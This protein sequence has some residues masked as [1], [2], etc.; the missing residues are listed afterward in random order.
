MFPRWREV[1][2]LITA[3]FFPYIDN[4]YCWSVVLKYQIVTIHK[5]PNKKI[6][7]IYIYICIGYYNPVSSPTVV[8]AWHELCNGLCVHV[9]I[10][11]HRPTCMHLAYKEVI[12]VIDRAPCT[13]RVINKKIF[14][15][16][17]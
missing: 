8:C 13:V 14:V 2:Y 3:I 6:K 1:I 7:N 12:N 16:Q 17:R 9:W 15:L 11:I 5:I 4:A 10:Q